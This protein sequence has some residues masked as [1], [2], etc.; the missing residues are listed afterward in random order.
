MPESNYE[1]TKRRVQAEFSSHSPD[2]IVKKFSLQEDA[3]GIYVPFLGRTYR[4]HRQTGQT[5]W[6]EDGFQTCFPAGFEETLSLFDLLID[7][8]PDCAPSF[9]YCKINSLPSLSR[10]ASAPGSDCVCTETAQRIQSAPAA[11]CAACARLGGRPFGIGDL[12]YRIPV[13][14]ELC[15]VAEFWFADEEFAPVL[16]ILWDSAVLRYV[17][18]ETVWYIQSHLL[19]R[20]REEM[21]C[22]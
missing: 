4:I 5:V 16:Q 18:Y 1:K 17:R 20:L 3:A 8:A 15:A 13:F 6:S 2:A 12:S 7:S 21:D 9:S 14:R 19:R 11:F 22:L 10:T